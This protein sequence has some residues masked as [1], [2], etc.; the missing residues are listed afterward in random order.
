MAFSPKPHLAPRP[1]SQPNLHFGKSIEDSLNVVKLRNERRL[2]TPQPNQ[3]NQISP[4][5][6]S[7]SLYTNF[8]NMDS[9]HLLMARQSAPA[10]DFLPTVSRF[11]QRSGLSAR[12]SYISQAYDKMTE[13][14]AILSLIRSVYFSTIVHPW[15]D[16]GL[17][18]RCS[19]VVWCNWVLIE[20]PSAT[21][22]R[23]S[24]L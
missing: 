12:E 1:V 22:A 14:R 21:L 6:P 10:L 16:V 15:L 13:R 2:L 24:L 17:P 7:T 4:I 18:P 5:R 11:S 3:T 20:P 9:R 23:D 8:P 19:Q